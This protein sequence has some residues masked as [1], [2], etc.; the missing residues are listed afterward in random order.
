MFCPDQH[1]KGKDESRISFK[2][3]L[4]RPDNLGFQFQE[5]PAAMNIPPIANSAEIRL[6]MQVRPGF[7]TGADP[8]RYQ[9]ALI[10]KIGQLKTLAEKLVAGKILAPQDR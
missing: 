10:D 1:L 8:K 9:V 3:I 4:P 5:K 6:V 7:R 2:V